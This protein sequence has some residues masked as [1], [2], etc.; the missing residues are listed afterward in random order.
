MVMIEL[1]RADTALG[2]PLMTY[3]DLAVYVDTST[4]TGTCS[5]MSTRSST[6]LH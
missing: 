1:A 6:S 3:G 5:P 2:E 4:A